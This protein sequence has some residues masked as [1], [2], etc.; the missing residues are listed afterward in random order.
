MNPKL[1]L[2]LIVACLT[3]ACVHSGSAAKP[4][5]NG[6]GNDLNALLAN[7]ERDLAPR[8]LPNGELYCAEVS[9]TEDAQDRCIADLE[10]LALDAETDK[11][12][13]LA[14]LRLGIEAIWKSL[15][16]CGFW[17][18]LFASDQCRLRP[19]RNK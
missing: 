18:R 8:T 1:A 11:A 3:A 6:R 5:S 4:A 15:Y 17:K 19:G 2:V 13:G 7:A 14:N 16:G 10:D 9:T 12:V